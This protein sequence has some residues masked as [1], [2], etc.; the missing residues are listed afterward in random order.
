LL[1]RT[2]QL[3]HAGKGGSLKKEFTLLSLGCNQGWHKPLL[4]R[5]GE[6]LVVFLI[7]NH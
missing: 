1:T 2:P 7:K 6:V 5:L 3:A 4:D